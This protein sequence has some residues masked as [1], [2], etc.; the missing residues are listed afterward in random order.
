L[1]SVRVDPLVEHV[2]RLAGG[3]QGRVDGAAQSIRSSWRRPRFEVTR[4]IPPTSTISKRCV[5]A[6]AGVQVVHV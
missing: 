4:S 6:F 2:A 3:A 5:P 1:R